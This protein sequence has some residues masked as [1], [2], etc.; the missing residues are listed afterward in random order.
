MTQPVGV[1]ED[2]DLDDPV[3]ADRE[4]EDRDDRRAGRQHDDAWPAVD[5]RCAPVRGHRRER[6]RPLGH[7]PC[8]ADLAGRAGTGVGAQHDVGV[9]HREQAAQIAVPGR[10]LEGLD[11]ASLLGRVGG[12]AR[13]DPAQAAAGP[14]G[15]LGRGG[16]RPPDDGGDLVER[17]P[18]QV[19]QDE[20]EPL[21]GVSVSRT[22]SSAT[23]TASAISASCSGSVPSAGATSGSGSSKPAGSSRRARRARSRSR[24]IRA[25]TVVSHPARFA[26]SSRSARL[27]RNQVSCTASSASLT[28][29]SSRWATARSRGRCASNTSTSVSVMVCLPVPSYRVT[30]GEPP[31]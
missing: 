31:T 29:P 5:H 8:A 6:R 20:G 16:R 30:S 25:T 23:P 22:T 18:E 9:E 17:D 10:G 27:R 21:A 12:A 13:L 26:M 4:A 1:G 14:A 11:E 2:V 19:V 3:G 7:R 28:E 15:Q 24:Q